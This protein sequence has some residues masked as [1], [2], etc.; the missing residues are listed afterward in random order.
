MT[1]LS[2]RASHDTSSRRL[3]ALDAARG[4]AILAMIVYHSVWDLGFL[5]LLARPVAL[6]PPWQA[7]AR[8]I[9]A[10]FLTLVGVSLV[11]AHGE[12]LRRRAFTRRLFLVAGAALLVSAATY[13]A[14]PDSYVFFGILHA[15]AL[16]SVL[17]VP[18]LRAP[19]SVVTLCA[20]LVFGA[21]LL[22]SGVDHPALS[23]LGLRST[24]PR[25][26]DYV[27]VFPWFGFILAGMVLGR[28]GARLPGAAA[29]KGWEPA[30]WFGRSL[31]WGGRKSLPIYLVHQPV[32]LALLYPLALVAAPQSN[33]E[34]TRFMDA[35]VESCGRA[36]GDA[37]SC[38]A[39]AACTADRLKAEELWAD[40]LSDR[41]SEAGRER[42]LALARACMASQSGGVSPRPE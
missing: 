21:P 31:V 25:T 1:G 42:A 23:F 14:F 29:L 41:L 32:L 22:I 11:L 33:T 6:D 12:G 4:V 5:G 9:A 13:L 19:V 16:G 27:P 3:Q 10:S 20:A 36:G 15:I 18:F 30:G 34:A 17:A 38:E 7:F 35:F 24:P 8:T 39:A 26:N 40:A 28:V 2:F 37:A